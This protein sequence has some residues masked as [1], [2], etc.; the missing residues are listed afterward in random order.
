MANALAKKKDWNANALERVGSILTNLEKTL[1]GRAKLVEALLGGPPDPTLEYAI[2]LIADPRNDKQSLAAICNDGRLS[3]SE[4]FEGAKR[5]M[6]AIAML[7]A[8]QK[9]AEKLPKVAEDVVMRSLP[10]QETCTECHGTKKIVWKPAEGKPQ[11]IPCPTCGGKGTYLVTPDFERQE[12]VLTQLGGLGVPK[13]PA[14]LI[15]QRDQSKHLTMDSSA[16]GHAKLLAA[17][18]K[19]LYASRVAPPLAS[20][21]EPVYTPDESRPDSEGP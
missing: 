12:F 15:D 2:G 5:G 3:Y 21:D 19:V 17:A 20:V 13:G 10:H 7:Q 11:Q 14:V 6:L 4:V 1:G 16:A 18:D 8:V 9:V